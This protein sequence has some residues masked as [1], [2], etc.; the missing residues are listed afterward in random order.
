ATTTTAAPG[1]LTAKFPASDVAQLRVITADTLAKLDGGDQ[2]GATRRVK[3]LETTWD[4]DQSSLQREDQNSWHML[5]RQIDSVLS[6]LRA[7][8]PNIGA[9]RGA[10]HALLASLS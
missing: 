10:L 6:A 1:T 5:D 4:T 9:E 8:R 3:D 2:S 7:R